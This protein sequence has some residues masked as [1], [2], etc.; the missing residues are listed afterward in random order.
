MAIKLNASNSHMY[1]SGANFSAST[2]P[3]TI[4][5]WINA[6]WN[7]GTVASF[8]GMYN[9]VPLTGTPTTGLQIGTRNGAGD[10]AIW[11][12]GGTVLVTSANAVMTP[13]SNKYAMVTY[14]YD[15]TTHR[16]YLN[17]VLLNTGTVTQLPGTF[18]QIFINGY[19]PTGNA[20]ETAAYSL[21]TY[22][23]YD[24]D[25]SADELITIYNSAGTR[26]GIFFG[27]IVRYEFDELAEGATATAAVDLSGHNNPMLYSGTG[28]AITYTYTTS[29]AD[30]NTRP[31][32]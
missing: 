23:Y 26:N 18:T 11:T 14:T 15:G 7:G 5:V 20:N 21:D 12:Y 6:N 31:V 1:V 27:E 8:V 24:R 29:Y 9:G 32:L 2:S 16:L 13:Y 19:P 17:G 30:S 4:N 28:T 3:Y 10:V 22:G 25:L